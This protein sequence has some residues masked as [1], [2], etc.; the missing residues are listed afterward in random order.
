MFYSTE[1]FYKQTLP[2]SEG[3]DQTAQ[4]PGDTFSHDSEQN[5]DFYMAAWSKSLKLWENY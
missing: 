5:C 4:L 2:D 3:P 1:W